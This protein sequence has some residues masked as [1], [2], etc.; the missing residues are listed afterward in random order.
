MQLNA[1][2][3]DVR[4]ADEYQQS[5]APQAIHIPLDQL[6]ARLTELDKNRPIAV[7]CRSGARAEMAPIC[8]GVTAGAA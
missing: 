7:H 1:Q 4:T 3:L 2:L 5:H 8:A 6:A